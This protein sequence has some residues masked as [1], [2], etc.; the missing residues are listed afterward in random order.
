MESWFDNTGIYI[1]IT[2][3]N[4]LVSKTDQIE[5]CNSIFIESLAGSIDM[6]NDWL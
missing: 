5:L 6:D 3:A 1:N 4:R 2:I